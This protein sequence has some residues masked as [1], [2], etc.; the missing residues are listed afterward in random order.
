M[1][2]NAPLSTKG[3]HLI[4]RCQIRLLAHV[5]LPLGKPASCVSLAG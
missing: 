1:T 4:E 5:A 2:P 3:R